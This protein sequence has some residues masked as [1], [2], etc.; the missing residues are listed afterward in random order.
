MLLLALDE[1]QL[2]QPRSQ[3]L[4]YTPESKGKRGT[5]RTKCLPQEHT[6]HNNDP[7]IRKDSNPDPEL[8]LLSG[9]PLAVLLDLITSEKEPQGA[10][11][12]P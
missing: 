8:D 2:I 9:V 10:S 11:N 6:Q 5:V 7:S 3:L 12:I 1:M 4:V